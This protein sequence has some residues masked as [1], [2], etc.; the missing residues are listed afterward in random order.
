[1]IDMHVTRKFVR[2]GPTLTTLFFFSLMQGRRIKN[3]TISQPSNDFE[4][5]LRSFV[6]FKGIRTCIAKKP[7]IF[8]WFSGLGGGGGGGGVKIEN[9]KKCF[10]V[11][12]NLC[13]RKRGYLP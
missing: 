7:Y 10:L 8:L 6:I 5:W 9:K 13:L 11:Y 12:A 2:G 4:Y 3:T 1:M